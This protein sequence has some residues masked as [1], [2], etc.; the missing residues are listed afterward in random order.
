MINGNATL[1]SEKKEGQFSGRIK[2]VKE[3]IS[4]ELNWASSQGTN[5]KY[6]LVIIP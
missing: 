1:L 5:L 4:P 6:L 3:I 2:K